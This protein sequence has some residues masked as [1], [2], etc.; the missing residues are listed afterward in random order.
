MAAWTGSSS[1]LCAP[2]Y[3]CVI[4]CISLIMLPK[5][6]LIVCMNVQYVFMDLPYEQTGDE[7]RRNLVKESGKVLC[8]QYLIMEIIR[9][10]KLT[11]MV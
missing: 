6:N 11:V 4:N 7:K 9:Q 5:S 1:V 3:Q 8:V 2:A 10:L